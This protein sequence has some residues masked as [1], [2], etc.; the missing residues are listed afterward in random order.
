MKKMLTALL[1]LSLLLGL[2]ACG[3]DAAAPAEQTPLQTTLQTPAQSEAADTQT[4]DTKPG[5]V[6]YLNADSTL[7][8]AWK[9]LAQT[10]TEATGTEVKIV[11][12]ADGTYAQTLAAQMGRDGMP[13]LFQ[14]SGPTELEQWKDYCLDLSGS[15]VY[16]QLISDDF[17]LTQGGAVYGVSYSLRSY[18]LIVNTRLLAEA[19]YNTGSIRSFADLKKVAESITARKAELGFSAFTSAGM[20]N[21][22]AWRFKTHLVNL[23]IYFEYQES[24]IHSTSAIKGTY[25]NN[26]HNIWDLYIQNATCA[27]TELATKTAADAMAE[28]T[29]GQAVF[30]QNGT[31]AYNDISSV[32]ENNLSIIPL[33]IGVGDEE[34]QGLCTGTQ[35]Y[36]CVNAWA[37]EAD[38]Q[39]TLDFLNWCVTSNE[40]TSAMANSMNLDIPYQSA[41]KTSNPLSQIAI[42]MLAEGRTPVSWNFSTMPSEAW[43]DGVGAALTAYAAGTGDWSAVETAFV[44]GWAT[45]YAKQNG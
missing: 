5:T 6:Y 21:S 20:D 38:I 10:Y 15:D 3:Q 43:K 16:G 25:L 18:G 14:V 42:K 41:Q 9:A 34:N 35:N 19:G 11:T 24:G 26:L 22:S 12:A 44:D 7:D 39:A 2:T 17:A 30:Y 29:S 13:T 23:P 8:A 31:W 4:E 45:E 40:G 36:W 28:F 32:G 33:Y 1:A 27:P 37:D